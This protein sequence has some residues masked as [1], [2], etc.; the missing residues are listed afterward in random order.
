[1]SLD[2]VLKLASEGHSIKEVVVA[3]FIIP[4]I[5][6]SNSYKGLVSPEFPSFKLIKKNKLNF[7]V[8]SKDNKFVTNNIELDGGFRLEKFKD[9]EVTDVIQGLKDEKRSFFSFN[10]LKY[11]K[12][13]SFKDD[14]K[15]YS[16]HIASIENHYVMAYSLQYTDE[17]IYTDGQ[18]YNPDAFFKKGS[19]RVPNDIFK[20]KTV[21]YDL[22]LELSESS[23]KRQNEG[24]KINIVERGPS[25]VITLVNS[26]TYIIDRAPKQMS[27]LVSDDNGDFDMDLEAAHK[28]NKELLQEIL[29]EEVCKLIHLI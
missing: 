23:D 4:P 22:K 1:M 24:I 2:K 19:S 7:V 5:V 10:T 9:G 15:K 13:T 20:G 12:W 21:D 18:Q 8:N 6:D 25:K 28:K 26:I 17:F 16:K 29:S 3:F 14:V 27:N 11:L